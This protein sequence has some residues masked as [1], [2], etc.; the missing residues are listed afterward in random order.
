MERNA[1]LISVMTVVAGN[2]N[3]DSR[4]TMGTSRRATISE[5][6]TAS[7]LGSSSPKKRVM[8]VRAMVIDPRPRLGK[9]AEAVVT[10]SAVL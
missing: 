2:S 6:A 8:S 10:K 3:A 7:A 9:K 4:L 5:L 1:L